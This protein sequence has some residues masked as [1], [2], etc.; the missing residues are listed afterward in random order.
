M[1]AGGR[2]VYIREGTKGDMKIAALAK[3]EAQKL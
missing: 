3:G 2:R 1:R